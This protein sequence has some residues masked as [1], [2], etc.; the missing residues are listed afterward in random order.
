MEVSHF[1]SGDV[2]PDFGYG[3]GRDFPVVVDL[4]IRKAESFLDVL[5]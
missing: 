1:T 4:A 5:R 2:F 3:V